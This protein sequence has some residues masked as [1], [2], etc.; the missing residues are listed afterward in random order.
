MVLACQCGYSKLCLVSINTESHTRTVSTILI[1]DAL[2]DFMPAQ[3]CNGCSHWLHCKDC[4]G[5]LANEWCYVCCVSQ[6]AIY[7]VCFRVAPSG[8]FTLHIILFVLM[9]IRAAV[10]HPVINFWLL[11]CWVSDVFCHTSYMG[12]LP[13]VA[14]LLCLTTKWYLKLQTAIMQYVCADMHPM[15]F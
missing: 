4:T 6:Q 7:D 14:A 10:V 11:A 15:L 8:S 1:M 12:A 2:C 13:P 5:L 3:E 9:I